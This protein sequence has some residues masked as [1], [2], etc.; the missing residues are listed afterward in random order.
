MRLHGLLLVALVFAA[1]CSTEPV[2]VAPG[3]DAALE[4]TDATQV[5]P[6]AGLPSPDAAQVSAD[7]GSDPS[8]AGEVLADAAEPADAGA[9]PADAAVEPPDAAQAGVDAGPAGDTGP[10]PY[11][12]IE[13]LSDTALK[14]ALYD[15]VKGHT[16]LDYDT[17]SKIVM[18]APGGFD[19]INGKVECIYSGLQFDSNQLD[20]EGGFNMEHS[21]PKSE[22]AGS[23][24]AESDLHHLFPSERN[25]NSSRS[26]YDFGFTSCTTTCKAEAG[27]SK[28]GPIVGG[29][30]LVFEVRPERR[31]DIARAHFYFSVR[32]SL[33]IPS[34]EE[35]TLRQWNVSDPPDDRER[36]RNL[37]IEAIQKKRNPFVD[38][39]DF[40]DRIADF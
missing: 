10:R 35:A 21:W 12:D 8:D 30:A 6:D 16:S 28:L 40:V 1:G 23:R 39:P 27:G 29:T 9:E 37:A 13:H 34:T 32:Y 4:S 7:V 22:G 17:G 5:G 25:I 14:T 3:S 31:G 15:L 19:V 38:R 26:S 18:T 33:H 36:A 20:Q 2:P 24:P 11:Q